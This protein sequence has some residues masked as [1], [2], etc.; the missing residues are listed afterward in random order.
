MDLELQG[1]RVVITG[2][3]KGI[4]LAT[5]LSFAREGAQPVIVARSERG[6][7]DARA[8]LRRDTGRDVET[9]AAD[10]S[11][12]DG[13]G[14]LASAAADCDILVDNAGAIPGGSLLELDDEHWRAAWELKLFGYIDLTRRMLPVMQS[15][16]SGVIANIIG[17]AGAAP[18]FDYLCGSTANAA[19]IAFTRA[20]GAASVRH[21]VRVF[22]VNPSLTHSDRMETLL[23]RQAVQKWGDD[24][25]WAEQTRELP[26]GRAIH[27]REIADL[28]VFGCSV[29]A[30]YLSGTVIDVDGGQLYAGA[31]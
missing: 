2:G 15:R 4:G 6:L 9:L 27:A 23:R 1:K 25:R 31:R 24:S 30:G 11:T 18:R 22:G 26:F 12:T 3:S 16:G 20:V 7:A 29:R 28:T 8:A 5:A 10:L 14:L 21:G 17:M 19:L 13:I